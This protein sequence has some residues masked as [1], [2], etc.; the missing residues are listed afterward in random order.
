MYLGHYKPKKLFRAR[1]ISLK[2]L[3]IN[4]LSLK[5]VQLVPYGVF[6]KRYI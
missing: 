6:N 4:Y 3:K 1:E 5:N 2:D